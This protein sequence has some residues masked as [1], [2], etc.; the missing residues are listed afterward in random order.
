MSFT[1]IR[2]HS[3]ATQ[4]RQWRWARHPK[5]IKIL[6]KNDFIC[7][8]FIK[9][10][11]TSANK[12]LGLKMSFT[13]VRRHSAATQCRQRHWTWQNETN[14]KKCRGLRQP[15]FLN[16]RYCFW[17]VSLTQ[18]LEPCLWKY[19]ICILL[20]NF[21]F[22]NLRIYWNTSIWYKMRASSNANSSFHK[23]YRV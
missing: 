11:T 3:A 14:F 19:L 8:F 16:W 18:N 13:R 9:V 10:K 21:G 1:R 6:W 4:Y 15:Y 12:P 23:Y 17:E 5:N 7:G 20:G 2:R 22:S